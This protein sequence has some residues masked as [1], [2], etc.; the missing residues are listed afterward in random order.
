[1]DKI[2]HPEIDTEGG[3]GEGR[4]D[5][6]TSITLETEGNFTKDSWEQFR[7]FIGSKYMRLKGF[8]SI[9]SKSYHIDATMDRFLIEPSQ[10]SKTKRN[11]LVL[12]GRR[13]NEEEIENKFLNSIS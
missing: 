3:L 8:I 11:Q 7:K 1:M 10:K 13:L 4:P 5:P 2:S 6:V 12:I 9:D